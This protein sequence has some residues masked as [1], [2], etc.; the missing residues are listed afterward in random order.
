MISARSLLL[1]FFVCTAYN[2]VNGQSGGPPT[3]LP[4]ARAGEPT[5]HGI[6]SVSFDPPGLF[7]TWEDDPARSMVI[8]WHTHHTQTTPNIEYRRRNQGEWT[9]VSKQSL[10][11][12]HSD[13]WVHRVRLQGLRPATIY[14]FRWGAGS[15]VYHFQTM[16]EQADGEPVRVVFG[17]DT[18][19]RRSMM[20][21]MNRVAAAT[22]PDFIVWGGDFAYADG[23][24]D[25][26]HFWVDWF[27]SIKETLITPDR[28][29]I[30]IVLTIGNHEIQ[31][32]RDAG[33]VN[34]EATDAYRAEVAP[35][36][37][38]LFAFPGQPGYGALEFGDYLTLLLLD[39][40]HAN[41][42]DGAQ[43]QWL[44]ER[45]STASGTRHV[46]P[47]YHVSAYPS[48]YSYSGRIAT[49]IRRHWV[50]LFEQHEVRL[51]FEHDDHTYKRTFPVRRGIVDFDGI[52]Y[53]G[54]GAWGVDTRKPDPPERRWFLVE[55]NDLHH[56]IVADIDRDSINLRVLDLNGDVMDRLSIPPYD[57]NM[58]TA[59]K[60]IFP[61]A[62]PVGNGFWYSDWFGLFN[63]SRL[64]W[65]HHDEHGWLFVRGRAEQVIWFHDPGNGFGW[66]WTNPGIY[67]NLFR[68][69]HRDWV[70]LDP[71]SGQLV[72]GLWF[73]GLSDNVG[74]LANPHPE[75]EF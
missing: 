64:P 45:L 2:L 16:P 73:F 66:F 74:W 75:P 71:E 17:G 69:R 49:A 62:Y 43:T 7:L 24:P 55:S 72:R 70:R 21:A 53:M 14:E 29:V 19:H 8:D 31:K 54:G 26:A 20:D 30:P 27:S 34:Y 15:A 12:P 50:P 41:P 52:V 33:S 37:F 18:M 67:P 44:R 6:P 46:I 4:L 28:R 5:L 36:F 39:S 63:T 25:R 32:G 11:F 3:T 59:V 61:L 13:H 10:R 57:D 23:R 65:I 68:M 1:V 56:C 47:V 58:H 42:V 38:G 48:F 9:A 22:N 60:Q 35:Y 51:V 40:A